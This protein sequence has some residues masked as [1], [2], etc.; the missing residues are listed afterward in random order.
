MITASIVADSQSPA[1]TR[2]TTFRPWSSIAPCISRAT[3][4]SVRSLIRACWPEPLRGSAGGLSTD[5]SRTCMPTHA[6]RR[7]STRSESLRRSAYLRA[8]SSRRLGAGDKATRAMRVGCSMRTSQHI[9]VRWGAGG[10]RKMA[11]HGRRSRRA[12]SG[13][14]SLDCRRGGVAPL[15]RRGH[16]AWALPVRQVRG[17]PACACEGEMTHAGRGR[18][19]CARWNTRRRSPRIGQCARDHGL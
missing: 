16:R 11:P 12:L 19:T 18:G 1:G 14:P 10:C 2:L 6:G 17:S 15:G 8:P 4:S 9:H 13:A 3:G 7:C 5:C